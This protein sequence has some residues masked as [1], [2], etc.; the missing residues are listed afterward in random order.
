MSAS[1]YFSAED[2]KG[3]TNKTKAV[4]KTSDNLPFRVKSRLSCFRLL[5]LVRKCH[6][7][8]TL[9]FNIPRSMFP[10]LHSAVPKENSI[11]IPKG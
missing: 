9:T 8:W 2:I 1:D 5:T 7:S 11:K 3:I 10:K 6:I 4:V